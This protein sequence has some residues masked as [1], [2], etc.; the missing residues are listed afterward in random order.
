MR[1]SPS[2]LL[3]CFKPNSSL[4]QY[5]ELV[6]RSGGFISV[7]REREPLWVRKNPAEEEKGLEKGE[8]CE[9]QRINRLRKWQGLERGKSE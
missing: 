7:I 5:E 6:K 4:A 8:P 1:N 3:T 2:F 9:S